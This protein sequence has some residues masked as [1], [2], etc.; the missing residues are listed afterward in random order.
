MIYVT[1]GTDKA[2]GFRRLI[3]KCDELASQTNEE[4][5][6]QMAATQH[7]PQNSKYFR[8]TP[9]S[10]HLEYFEKARIIISHC[11]IGAILNAR[12]FRKPL[13][14][15]PRRY[16]YKELADEHQLDFARKI[17]AKKLNSIKV[18]YEMDNLKQA[19]LE[20]QSFNVTTSEL[21]EPGEII[22]AIRNYV[23]SCAKI[24]SGIQTDA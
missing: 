24:K 2:F 7:T 22:E 15:V 23:K 1:V 11:S 18:V 14:V 4:V 3:E 16:A 17:Q 19:I 10:R 6:I 20:F 8:Y 9:F 21:Q 12:K 5:V 13:V